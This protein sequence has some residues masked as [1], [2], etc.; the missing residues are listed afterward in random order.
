MAKQIVH[1][2]VL[3][4][5]AASRTLASVIVV[6]NLLDRCHQSVIDLKR[7]VTVRQIGLVCSFHV[8]LSMYNPLAVW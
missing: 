2:D 4:Q 6:S 8:V 7:Q 3:G 1:R 5:L